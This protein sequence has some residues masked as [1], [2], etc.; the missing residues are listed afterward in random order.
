MG[1]KII[2]VNAHVGGDAGYSSVNVN[3]TLYVPPSHAVPALPGTPHF[4]TNKFVLPSVWY[5][6]VLYFSLFF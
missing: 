4:H 3:V 1:W 2:G 5:F 6:Y